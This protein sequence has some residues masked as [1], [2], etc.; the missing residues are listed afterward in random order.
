MKGITL[1]AWVLSTLTLMAFGCKK[2]PSQPNNPTPLEPYYEQCLFAP[3]DYGSANWRIPA[4]RV[5]NDGS[6]L[7]FTDKRK[8]NQGDLPEDI[9]IVVRRSTDQGRT[10]SE[11]FTLAEGTGRKQGFG[12]C[13]V[14]QSADGTVVTAYVGGNGLWQSTEADPD[15]SYI[16]ISHDGGLSWEPRRDITAQLWGSTSSRGQNYKGAFFGSGNGLIL[17]KGE[18]SGRIMFV[19]AMVRKTGGNILDNFAVYS[20]DNGETWHISQ[21]AY[22]GGDEAKVVQ[23]NDGSVLMSIR[24][25][26]ARGY[27]LSRDG[28]ETWEPQGRWNDLSTNACNGDI[29]RYN[30]SILL[31]SLPNSMN[32]EKVS[33]FISRDEGQSWQLAKQLSTY[34]SCY[35][36]LSLLPDG[37]IV[38]YLEEDRNSDGNYEL[39]YQCFTLD[40]L[41]SE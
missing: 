8:Y 2:E 11:P 13:A 21:R 24:Q 9:D 33:I 26:G 39:Y 5:L 3:G 30:D 23:L 25:S 27:A 29:L 4:I 6:M 34:P 38:C 16:Q 37:R 40:W 32:R 41:L 19:T 36:S 12:D 14:V 17:T 22:S 1:P 28:G 20:D 7:C 10:W 35:S 31:H 18:H 15:R